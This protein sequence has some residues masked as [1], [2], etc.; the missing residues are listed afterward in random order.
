MSLLSWSRVYGSGRHPHST[1]SSD[2]P[3]LTQRSPKEDMMAGTL[4]RVFTS[5]AT[6]LM[7]A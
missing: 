2:S 4:D 6:H 3:R 7:L 5:V 1:T